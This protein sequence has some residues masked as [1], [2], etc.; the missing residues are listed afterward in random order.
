MPICQ[1]LVGG[2]EV[3]EVDLDLSVQHLNLV[4]DLFN[5][6]PL[7]IPV[8]VRPAAVE[9]PRL[10]EDLVAREPLDLEKVYLTLKFG[11]LVFELPHA[12][13]QGA[14][15]PGERFPVDDPFQM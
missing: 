2:G 1:F 10:R 4:R 13:G 3:A 14:M 7:L 5:D 9:V 11:N 12:L 6:P 15:V 8:K